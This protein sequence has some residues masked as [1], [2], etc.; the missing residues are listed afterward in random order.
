MGLEEGEGK[1]KRGQTCERIS[2]EPDG[3]FQNGKG[4][5][6]KVH[7]LEMEFEGESVVAILYILREAVP[8]PESSQGG[9]A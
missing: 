3:Q 8:G 9:R 5:S 2:S 1:G 6:K 4:D 7:L